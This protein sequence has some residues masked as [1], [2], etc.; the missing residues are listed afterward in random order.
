MPLFEMVAFAG[1]AGASWRV[2][3]EWTECLDWCRLG[4][5]FVSTRRSPVRHLSQA[6]LEEFPGRDRI[7]VRMFGLGG[8][9][10]VFTRDPDLIQRVTHSQKYIRANPLNGDQIPWAGL[11]ARVTGMQ[12][13]LSSFL[14]QS[15][16]FQASGD[17]HRRQRDRFLSFVPKFLTQGAQDRI[18]RKIEEVL[19]QRVQVK[20]PGA[21][22][23]DLLQEVVSVVQLW[24]ISDYELPAEWSVERY[25]EVTNSAFGSLYAFQAPRPSHAAQLEALVND[26]MVRSGPEG[27]IQHMRDRAPKELSE[28]QRQEELRHNLMAG[29]FLGQQ[30]LANCAFWLVLRLHDDPQLVDLLRKD[31]SK[32][33]GIVSEELRLHPPSS[34][35]LMPYYA[36]QDDNHG[37]LEIPSGSLVAMMPILM[38]MN[39]DLHSRP[40]GFLRSR[41]DSEQGKKHNSSQV[42]PSPTAEGSAPI[43][44]VHACMV[45]KVRGGASSSRDGCP[46]TGGGRVGDRA[47]YCPFGVG[48]ATCPMQG[49]SLSVILNLVRVIVQDWDVD[50]HDAK[51]LSTAPV[52]Q[53]VVIDTGSRPMKRLTATF[54]PRQ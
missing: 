22:L 14:L 44:D 20:G 7:R 34:P 18:H 32:L 33:P 40:E 19:P 16:W 41:F 5:Y 43:L 30:S 37:G 38:H 35:F 50:V 10:V 39:E 28:K 9:F 42:C 26:M 49:F 23:F 3:K 1:L 29:L 4:R 17:V 2:G 47:G 36:V 21:D 13:F 51:T 15:I 53:H 27:L 8:P 52:T 6:L 31:S 46:V 25:C 11:I 24:F 12:P 48:K 45:S 54:R